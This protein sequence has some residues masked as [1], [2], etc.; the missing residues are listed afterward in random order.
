MKGDNPME[1]VVVD[2]KSCNGDGLCA[3]V[4]PRKLIAFDKERKTPASIPRAAELCI[5]CGHCLSVCPTG[6]IT[7]NGTSPADCREID[8]E[9]LPGFE[10]M[11]LLL[12]TRRSIR[13]YKKKRVDRGVIERLLDTCRYAPSGSNSQPVGWIAT[14]E[15]PRLRDLAQLVIDWMAQAVEAGDPDARRMH[16]D[17][18]VESWGRGEDRIFRGAP[19]VV[20]CHAPETASLPLENAIIAMTVFDLAAASLG[21]GTCWVGYLMLAAARHPPIREALRIPEGNRLFGAMVL[22]YPVYAYQRIPPRKATDLIW[23]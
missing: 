23:W 15:A 21:L 7:L 11:D 22:G 5:N 14:S 17:V 18:V 12:R 19:A 1:P 16:L 8:P 9:M 6:A 13:V 4:C 20:M 3:A 10:K 2:N